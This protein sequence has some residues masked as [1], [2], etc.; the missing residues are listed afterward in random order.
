[1]IKNKDELI[2]KAG[3]LSYRYEADYGGCAQCTIAGVLDAL[4]I[5]NPAIVK[6]GSGLAGGVA[7]MCDGV[8]GGYSGAVMMTGSIFG[9]RKSFLDN[10]DEDKQKS[11]EMARAVRDRFMSE[12]G[13]VICGELHM[14]IFGRRYDMYDEKDMEE[15]DEAGAHVDKCTSV[16]RLAAETAAGLILEEAER[17]GMS[18]E[19][20]R[21]K[22]EDC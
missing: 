11:Y 16:V 17:R 4:E 9:R 18:L 21:K 6:A 13:S 15:F 3:E 10:D 7:K 1:M 8:C 20:L 12:Y 5:N 14:K 22:A 2:R 19:V